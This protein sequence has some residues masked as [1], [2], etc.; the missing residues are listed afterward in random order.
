MR[1]FR[2]QLVPN[3]SRSHALIVRLLSLPV[4]AF[5]CAAGLN[6]ARADRN[7]DR[8]SIPGGTAAAY[9]RVKAIL[10]ETVIFLPLPRNESEFP[11]FADYSLASRVMLD[12]GAILS[13]PGRLSL[14]AGTDG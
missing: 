2:D 5:N 9:D 6:I 1:I 11:A 7:A 3:P 8:L 10:P 14:R 4:M 12:G 13:G